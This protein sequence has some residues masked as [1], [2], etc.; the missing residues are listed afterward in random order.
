MAKDQGADK[1][2]PPTQKKIRDA[3]KEGNV[4]K[5][6]ELTS[7]VLVLGWMVCGWLML[8]FMRLKL[9]RLFETSLKAINQPFGDALREVGGSAFE[10]LLWLTLPLLTMAVFLGAVVEFL[11]VGPILALGKLKP[12]MDKMNP[13]EGVKKMFSMDNLVELVKSTIK[14]AALVGIGSFVIYKML[15][16]L[17]LLPYAPPAAMGSGIWYGLVRIGV[18]TIFVFFFVSAIDVWYQKFSYLKQ[19]RMSRR[20]IQQEV[21]ENEGDPHVKSRRRQL[22]QEWSQQNMLNAVRQSNVVV[23]NPTHIAIALQYEHGITDL[24]VVVAKGEGYMAEAIKRAAAEAG[25]P[26]LQNVEL[27]RGLN[28]RAG[29]DEYIGNEF[30]EAVAEVLHWAETVRRLRDGDDSAPE[31]PPPLDDQR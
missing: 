31:L 20:D 30:F 17:M 22:H 14:S 2:E 4:A 5:S 27:A 9:I 10:T 12:A 21:K 29:L 3:R 26:I 18:W 8:D 7:T 25:V 11:Q 15:A 13:A 6:K 24:P 1:T 23:T 16:Q 28:E 19:L